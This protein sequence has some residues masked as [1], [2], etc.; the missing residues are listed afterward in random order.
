M[1]TIKNTWFTI[2]L[3]SMRE[4]TTK[5][6]ALHIAE[7][8]KHLKTSHIAKE[9][10]IS[11]QRAHALLTE[12]VKERI[13]V[14]IGAGPSSSYALPEYATSHLEIFPTRFHKSYRNTGLDEGSVLDE[15][16]GKLPSLKQ[17]QKNV[18]HI[19][20]FGFLEMLNNAIE[21]SET[22]HV[23]IEFFVEDNQV[24]FTI[25]DFGVGAFFNVMRKKSLD[26]E[27]EAIQDILK[28]KVTTDPDSHTG[29]GIFFTSKTADIFY[30][31][32][33]NNQLIVNNNIDDLFL[34]EPKRHKQG[35]KVGFRINSHSSRQIQDI[36]KKYTDIG[37]D[38]DFGFDRTEVKV[39]LYTREGI[40]LSRSQARRVLVGL[41]KFESIILDF[42]KVETVGQAFADEIFRV[43][44]NKNPNIQILPINMNEAVQFMVD[45]AIP[46]QEK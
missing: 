22:T 27:L 30:L 13:L 25:N 34:K 31:E 32:S 35:T 42:K 33:H 21:H 29:Q 3:Q 26:S 46:K 17:L 40:Y 9:L 12:L 44:Q 15:I 23:D 10:G 11:R 18:L 45:R 41:D 16:E 5:E 20:R 38:S 8:R 6:K 1:L 39:Q 14:H 19:I 7:K 36:F 4:N 2:D 43:F 28:G 24:G 37:D